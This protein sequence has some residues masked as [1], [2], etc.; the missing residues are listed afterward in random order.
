MRISLHHMHYLELHAEGVSSDLRQGSG[1]ALPLG[2]RAAC[3]DHGSVRENRWRIHWHPPQPVG[4]RRHRCRSCHGRDR[5]TRGGHWEQ[6][7]L[8]ATEHLA[9]RY[10]EDR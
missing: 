1:M 6:P 8:L 3:D 7:C 10:R 9:T 5:M 2:A 4:G